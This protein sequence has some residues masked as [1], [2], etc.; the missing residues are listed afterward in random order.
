M[1]AIESS[2]WVIDGALTVWEPSAQ[3]AEAPKDTPTDPTPPSFLQKDHIRGVL[4]QRQ[5]GNTHRAYTCA[6]ATLPGP[7][8]PDAMTQA[9]NNFVRSHEGLRSTFV[10]NTD[11][12]GAQG[13]DGGAS[14]AAAAKPSG[15]Q[16]EFGGASVERKTVPASVIDLVPRLLAEAPDD[17]GETTANDILN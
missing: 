15:G 7:L 12:A 8:N 17:A 13:T 4:T 14:D 6:V 3:M 16:P 5:A 11:T 1:K 9:V 2:E 10:V